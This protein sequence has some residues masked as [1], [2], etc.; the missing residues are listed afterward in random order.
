M[1]LNLNY[2][3]KSYFTGTPV[4]PFLTFIDFGGLSLVMQLRCFND[5]KFFLV[6]VRRLKFH[7]VLVLFSETQNIL[8]HFAVIMPVSRCMFCTEIILWRNILSL[9]FQKNNF[10]SRI[11]VLS[12]RNFEHV[13]F[14]IDILFINCFS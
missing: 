2:K 14:Y 3:K 1:L 11:F 12:V 7:I 8:T 6:F 9:K 13:D 4:F 10:S 5:L